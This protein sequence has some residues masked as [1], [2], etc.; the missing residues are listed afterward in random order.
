MRAI[1]KG[2]LERLSIQHVID[3]AT[4]GNMGCNGGDT[5]G[6]FSWMVGNKLVLESEYPLTLKTA[7]C[8]LRA[9]PSGVQINSNYTCDR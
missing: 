6:A 4:N 5:C 7:A 2:T 1:Q 9:T 3:C 8:K